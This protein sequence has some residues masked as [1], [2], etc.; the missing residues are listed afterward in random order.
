MHI[1]SAQHQHPTA[2]PIEQGAA[3]SAII[4]GVVTHSQ[5]GYV[6][7]GGLGQGVRGERDRRKHDDH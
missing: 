3:A 4:G 1:P 5:N 7:A 2:V 6:Q